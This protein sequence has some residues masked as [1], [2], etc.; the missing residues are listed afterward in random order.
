[1]PESTT[2]EQEGASPA[3]KP[4]F[5]IDEALRKDEFLAF[6]EGYPDAESVTNDPAELEKRFNVFEQKK[7]LTRDVRQVCREE[8]ERDIG[9]KLSDEE[10][11]VMDELVDETAIRNP[12]EVLRI[13]EVARVYK[14][15]NET[16]A[17]LEKRIAQQG[18]EVHMGRKWEELR[19]ARGG[20]EA[21]FIEAWNEGGKLSTKFL[22]TLE[23]VAATFSGKDDNRYRHLRLTHLR[24]E[25]ESG[26]GRINEEI[27]KIDDQIKYLEQIAELKKS[28]DESFK[29]LRVELM[30]GLTPPAEVIAA[31]R[32]KAQEKLIAMVEG[33]WA[34]FTFEKAEKA[35]AYFRQLE[36]VAK[37][38]GANYLEGIDTSEFIKK[39][40][41]F[42]YEE[43]AGQIET[44]VNKA[45]LG[46]GKYAALEK[47]LEKFITKEKIGAREGTEVKEFVT[48]TLQGIQKKL[49]SA[50]KTK[51]ILL[52]RLLVKMNA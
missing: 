8:I 36:K 44:A 16:I 4:P 34:A 5:D 12:D 30:G 21:E 29:K 31:V 25:A 10:L 3:E 1:M 14:E 27:K 42:T 28:A 2:T 13:A 17:E 43:A 49:D 45:A 33:V 39:L 52:S 22:A 47:S 37:E 32:G 26:G 50:D 19:T 15:N 11:K 18:G 51:K 6:L 38:K 46:M 41:A 20:K 24:D 48:E 9:L 23:A 7:E 35:E 40:H